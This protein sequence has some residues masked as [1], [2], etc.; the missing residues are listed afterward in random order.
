[1]AVH[2]ALTWTSMLSS[3]QCRNSS[4]FRAVTFSLL[5]YLPIIRRR[6]EECSLTDEQLAKVSIPELVLDGKTLGKLQVMGSH[7]QGEL[8]VLHQLQ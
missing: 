6:Q 8:L 4:P 3:G 2:V 7:D 1:M 5:W